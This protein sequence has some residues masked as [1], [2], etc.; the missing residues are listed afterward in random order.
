MKRTI[1]VLAL[2]VAVALAASAKPAE[3]H[4]LT[5]APVTL[6]FGGGATFVSI[7]QV[8]DFTIP[9]RA[10]L[11]GSDMKGGVDTV[12]VGPRTFIFQY[13]TVDSMIFEYLFF[14]AEAAI[15][16]QYE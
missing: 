7:E 13:G 10:V 4:Y 6:R 11:Y 1:L 16:V 15:T 3:Y 9:S 12:N 2:L 8:K 5:S 14:G